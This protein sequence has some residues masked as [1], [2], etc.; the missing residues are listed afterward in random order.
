[1]RALVVALDAVAALRD[2]AGREEPRLAVFAIAAELA[3]ADAVRV[4][5]T[6]SLRPVHEGDMHDLRRVVRTLELRMAP[7]PS[8]LKLALEVRPD[9]VLLAGE[10]SRAGALEAPPLD[11]PALRHSAAAAARALHEAHIPVW[12]RIAPDLETVKAARAAGLTGVELATVG[13]ADLPESERRPALERLVDA[14]R[15]AAKL[16]L[17]LAAG[18]ALDVRGLRALVAAAPLL[19]SVCVGRELVARALGVGVERAVRDFQ[20]ALAS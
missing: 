14:A 8:L 20:A 12:A 9:R 13:I 1:M 11:G 4:G 18:G 6:E 5:A 3:G 10:P 15:L 7:T 16:H 17:P 19:E 2:A